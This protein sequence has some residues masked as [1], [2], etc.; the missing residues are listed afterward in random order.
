MKYI[1]VS[2]LALS[3]FGLMVPNAF[4]DV[5]DWVKNTAGW[6]AADAISE[7]EFVNAIAYLAE[8][9]I[10]QLASLNQEINSCEFEHIPVL[11]NLN[12]QQK[13]DVC[14]SAQIDYLSERLDCSPCQPAI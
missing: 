6:W 14:K 10:I 5:P 8:V 9:G 7:T 13:I 1:I 3:V 11:I 2:L 4:A 12:Q